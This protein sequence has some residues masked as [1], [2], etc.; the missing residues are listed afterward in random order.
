ME[1]LVHH[2]GSIWP[3]Q[4]DVDYVVADSGCWEWDNSQRLQQG[5]GW[6]YGGSFNGERR[7]HRAAWASI[8]GPI[9][10]GSHIHHVCENKACINPAHLECKT[11]SGHLADHHREWSSLTWDDVRTM[12]EEFAAGGS[13]VE[14]LAERYGIGKSQVHNILINHNWHDPEFKPGRRIVCEEC[15]IAFIAKRSHQRF[16]RTSHR[17]AWNNRK[18]LVPGG[19]AERR[20]GRAA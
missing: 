18:R 11:H 13:S 9:P 15:G 14:A 5:Y 3:F 4:E 12:R 17:K 8:N 10:D 2:P 1:P 20:L 6:I 7:A 19:Y 16:C